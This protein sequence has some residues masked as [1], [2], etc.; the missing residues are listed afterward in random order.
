MVRTD[1]G[2]TKGKMVAQ[3]CHAT[4]MCYQ[5]ALRHAPN[6]VRRW[7]TRGQTKVALQANGG[8]DELLALQAHAMSLG[9]VAKIVHDAG[10]TQ[11]A[12]GSATVLGLGPGAFVSLPP[13]PPS[14]RLPSSS[15]AAPEREKLRTM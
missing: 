9:V 3:C 6:L 14:P 4:L 7:E 2:M 8:E 11:I 10:R 15:C 5:A 1:L 12:A 13:L